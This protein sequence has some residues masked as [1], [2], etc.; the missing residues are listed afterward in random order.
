MFQKY[1]QKQRF[2]GFLT[3]KSKIYVINQRF[4]INFIR[5]YANNTKKQAKM[6]YL[7]AFYYKYSVS[8]NKYKHQT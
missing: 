5:F 7:Y 1:I 4:S 6:I 3:V 2:K 8:G